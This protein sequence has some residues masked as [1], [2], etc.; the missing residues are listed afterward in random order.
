MTYVEWEANKKQVLKLNIYD[1]NK[2]APQALPSW[3][4]K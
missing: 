2:R 4:G 3:P 1:G